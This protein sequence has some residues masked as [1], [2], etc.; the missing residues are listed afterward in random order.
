MNLLADTMGKGKELCKQLLRLTKAR[1][2]W[3]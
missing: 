1:K 3:M 2:S